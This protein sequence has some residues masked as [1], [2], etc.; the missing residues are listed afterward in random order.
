LEDGL[1]ATWIVRHAITGQ[2]VDEHGTKKAATAQ[3]K[4]M[5]EAHEKINAKHEGQS[6]AFIAIKVEDAP[7]EAPAEEAA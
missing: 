3:A 5:T 1:M 7:T 4:Q 2:T 6:V